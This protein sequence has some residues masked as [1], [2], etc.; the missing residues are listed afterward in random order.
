MFFVFATLIITLSF[1]TF[2]WGIDD[3]CD[4][5]SAPCMSDTDCIE[6]V[7]VSKMSEDALKNIW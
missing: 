5:L 4:W 6:G 2:V 7:C 1:S 3:D